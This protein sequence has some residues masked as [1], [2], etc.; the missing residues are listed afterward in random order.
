VHSACTGTQF[1]QLCVDQ[2]EIALKVG[3]AQDSGFRDFRG[4]G[5]QGSRVSGVYGFRGVGIEGLRNGGVKG[6]R[7]QELRG[8]GF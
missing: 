2:S 7:V 4:V 1:Y 5:F 3:R 6:L 8:L